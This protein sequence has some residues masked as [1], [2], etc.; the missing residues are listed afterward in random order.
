MTAAGGRDR[1]LAG[2]ALACHPLPTAAVTGLAGL[3]GVA[4][5]APARTIGVLTLA[6]LAGQ[7]SIGWSNDWLDAARDLA[8]GRADKPVAAGTVPRGWVGRAGAGAAVL[9][10]PLSGALGAGAGVAH[11]VAVGSGWAYNLGLKRTAWSWAPYALTFGLLPSVATLS[12]PGP[13]DALSGGRGW[14]PAWAT[15]AGA[16]IGVGA[17]LI[18][19]LPDL[20]DDLVTGVRGLPHRIGRRATAVL[21][22][23]VLLASLVLVALGG[24][25]PEP[26]TGAGRPLRMAALTLGLVAALVAVASGLSGRSRRLPL[27][28]T[29]AVALIDVGLLLVSSARLA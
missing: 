20:D 14:A 22:P 12:S 3:L 21:A 15:G 1:P 19:V 11:V 18:N 29:A 24:H 7:L 6:V 26:L 23:L 4:V 9:T 16:L 13:A 10:L 27:L 17:H 8:V 5:G 28:A 25:G 2:L